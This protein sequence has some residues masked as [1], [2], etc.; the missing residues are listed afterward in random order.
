MRLTVIF[1]V[2]ANIGYF[3][4]G[5]WQE[6]RVGYWLPE[7]DSAYTEAAGERLVLLTETEDYLQSLRNET[8]VQPALETSLYSG[9]AVQECLIV[10]PLANVIEV[11]ELQ[12]RLFAV[13]V[14]S[15]ERADES[16]QQEDYWVHI[17]PLASRDAA[18]RLLREL[19]AQR[20]DSF[21]ITQGELTNG[22]SLGLFSRREFAKAVS[23]R[24]MDAGY[25][26]A[27]KSLPRVPEQWWLEMDAAVEEK[28]STSFWDEATDQFPELKTLRTACKKNDAL[29][30]VM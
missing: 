28:L 30:K 20:I 12:Q 5:S 21:V 16:S 13:G 25:E 15:K 6:S 22:I 14:S 1:L 7:S 17:P 23:R 29:K 4:W 24:L 26:V 27:I 9:D 19:Q 10:G 8:E 11:D 3:A 18:I 2:F